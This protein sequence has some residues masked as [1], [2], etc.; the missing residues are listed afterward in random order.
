ML[1][2]ARGVFPKPICVTAEQSAYPILIMLWWEACLVPHLF[3]EKD[4]PW[5]I[6]VDECCFTRPERRKL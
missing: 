3:K 4:E 6:E 1:F 5:R 2:S